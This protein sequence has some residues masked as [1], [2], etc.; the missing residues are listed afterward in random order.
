MPYQ[1]SSASFPRDHQEFHHDQA[2]PIEVSEKDLEKYSHHGV[3]R[4]RLPYSGTIPETWELDTSLFPDAE[5]AWL[6]MKEN[7]VILLVSSGKQI[8]PKSRTGETRYSAD[9]DKRVSSIQVHIRSR[10]RT[11]LP[12]GLTHYKTRLRSVYK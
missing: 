1:E 6:K 3:F 9:I 5:H 12:V 10:M 2:I 11:S 4:C 7:E 8:P